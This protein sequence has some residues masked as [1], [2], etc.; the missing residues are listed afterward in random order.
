MRATTAPSRELR[1]RSLVKALLWRMIGIVWT[2]VGAYLILL[3]VPP[4]LKTAAV[5]ATLIVIYHHS[6]RMVM[7]YL[8]ER[9]WASIGWG[10]GDTPA[11]MSGRARALWA[12][13]T[14]AALALIFFLLLAV[15]PRFKAR[16]SAHLTASAPTVAHHPA[17]VTRKLPPA[18]KNIQLF[19]QHHSKYLFLLL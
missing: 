16:Q 6:T 4:A 7:Y 13:C 11:P 9:V 18:S 19:I 17:A 8:Y 14:L 12:L 2:W 3:L 5:I 15:H 10:R 1:R